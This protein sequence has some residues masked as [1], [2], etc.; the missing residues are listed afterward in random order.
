MKR[1]RFDQ[2]KRSTTRIYCC[3]YIME[4]ESDLHIWLI[5]PALSI[6]CDMVEASVIAEIR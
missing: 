2:N 4:M 1:N 5:T 6:M 3:E